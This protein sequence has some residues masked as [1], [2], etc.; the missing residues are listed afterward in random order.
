MAN[1]QLIYRGAFISQYF[2]TAA[3][4]SIN[5]ILDHP[6]FHTSLMIC[7]VSL[8]EIKVTHVWRAS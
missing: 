6:L 8:T 7:G 1:L 3:V 2:P 5:I 4:V